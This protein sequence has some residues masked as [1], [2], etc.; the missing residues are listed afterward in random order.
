MAEKFDVIRFDGKDFA[1]WKFQMKIL[2]LGKKIWGNVDGTKEKPED[3]EENAQQ[4]A[5]WK[6][7]DNLALMYITQGLAKSQLSLVINCTT[8]K[9]MWD[10]LCTV[11]E[12][13]NSTSIHMLQAKFF[14]YKMDP[15]ED[16]TAHITK[17]ESLAQQL[18]D[19][20]QPQTEQAIITKIL[21]S[22]PPSYR[23]VISAWDSTVDA[24]RTLSNLTA[25]LIKEQEFERNMESL[26]IRD[27]GNEAFAASSS[28]HRKKFSKNGKKK[29]FAGKCNHCD[30][31]GHKEDACWDLHPELKPKGKR[32][33]SKPAKN[34][35]SAMMAM[36]GEIEA[37]VWIVDSG[38]TGHMC[39]ERHLFS[40]FTPFPAGAYNITAADKKKLPCKGVG[41]VHLRSK[42]GKRW[43]SVIL[44]NVLFVPGIGKNLFS[45]VAATTKGA[46]VSIS[47]YSCEIYQN[48]KC[49]ATAE[50]INRLYR[51]KFKPFLRNEANLVESMGTEKR[52]ADDL[53]LWHERLAHANDFLVKKAVGSKGSARS[54]ECIGCILGKQ[55]RHS[56]GHGP[57]TRET[58]P[59]KLIHG[60]VCGPIKPLSYGKS[61]FFLLL[62][63]DCT[64]MSFIYFMKTKCEV[65]EKMK[66]FLMDWSLYSDLKIERFRSDRGTEFLSK[67]MQEFLMSNSIRAEQS[68]AYAPQLNGFI[69]RANRTVCEAARSMIHGIGASP[70]LWAEAC[71]AA[72]YIQNRLPSQ[73]LDGKSP[74]ELTTGNVPELD[75][76]RVFGS[77]AFVH[78]PHRTKFDAKSTEWMLVGYD[79]RS[80]AYRVLNNETKRVQTHSHVM[81]KRTIQHPQT[82]Q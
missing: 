52:A 53:Q 75:H 23:G 57:K 7:N 81:R 4:L 31:V 43:E 61:K 47:E 1:L 48:G 22:L 70:E 20:G 14:D 49:V 67:E 78:D 37:G 39:A 58:V 15:K 25:R 76:I 74:F 2:L 79:D 18:A 5:S 34:E 56:F 21:C 27:S 28:T 24:A 13:K 77:R 66:Q 55:T 51:L 3:N 46:K 65:L 30:M 9:E 8:S 59:G 35:S 62:K 69:E 11:H 29:R 40:S 12:Q 68:P 19:M 36:A 41:N 71:A 63:D 60:D 42:V 82:L 32:Q 50:V 45:L 6:E 38:A 26:S 16:I 64:N 17:V 33:F 72:V 73:A 10:R 54:Q 80:K 44:K